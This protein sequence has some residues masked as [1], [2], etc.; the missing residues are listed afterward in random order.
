MLPFE[1]LQLSSILVSFNINIP[2]SEILTTKEAIQ[3]FK[4][5]TV[6]E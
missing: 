4:S 1:L 3:L 2:G 6:T 5:E